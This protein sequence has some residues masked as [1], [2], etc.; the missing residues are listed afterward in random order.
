MGNVAADYIT[1]K[2]SIALAAILFFP[3]YKMY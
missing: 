1:T 3:G 2:I